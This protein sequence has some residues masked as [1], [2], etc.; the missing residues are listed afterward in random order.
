MF[1][2]NN[3]NSINLGVYLVSSLAFFWAKICFDWHLFASNLRGVWQL[4]SGFWVS[5]L[6]SLLFRHAFLTAK[7]FFLYQRKTCLKTTLWKIILRRKNQKIPAGHFFK[8]FDKIWP[9]A[10]HL[11]RTS[12]PNC[13]MIKKTHRPQNGMNIASS[14]PNSLL[15]WSWGP[16]QCQRS[17]PTPRLSPALQMWHKM[18]STKA[19]GPTRPQQIFNICAN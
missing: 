4:G 19:F 11:D 13:Q 6:F 9:S 12:Q 8:N 15:T 1:S 3:L 5:Q 10:P 2:R 14:D 17:E 7:R 16:D 18:G